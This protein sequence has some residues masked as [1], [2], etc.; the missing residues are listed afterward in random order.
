[1]PSHTLSAYQDHPPEPSTPA[2]IDTPGQHSKLGPSRGVPP[3]PQ[4]HT[5]APS[6]PTWPNWENRREI[7]SSVVAVGMWAKNSC[8]LLSG[9][10]PASTKLLLR[11]KRTSMGWLAPGRCTALS[12]THMARCA[13][14]LVA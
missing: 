1:M 10:W 11:A 3:P 9:P 8:L 13:S 2:A 14:S 6:C 4:P 7:S 5:H 12:R